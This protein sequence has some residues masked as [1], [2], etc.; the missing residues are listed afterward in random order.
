MD[1]RSNMLKRYQYYSREGIVW[2]DWF[3]YEG[4]KYIWQLK[5]KLKNEYKDETGDIPSDLLQGC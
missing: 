3:K 1:C 2:T 5:N 4:E